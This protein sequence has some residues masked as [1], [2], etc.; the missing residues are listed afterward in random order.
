MQHLAFAAIRGRITSASRRTRAP[1]IF[2]YSQL[3]RGIPGGWIANCFHTVIRAPSCFNML[4]VF[5][6][7]SCNCRF[8]SSAEVDTDLSI[9]V[10]YTHH[11]RMETL[12]LWAHLTRS[13]APAPCLIASLSHHPVT[14]VS[15]LPVSQLARRLSHDPLLRCCCFW[16]FFSLPFWK[17]CGTAGMTRGPIGFPFL[18]VPVSAPSVRGRLRTPS[19][20]LPQSPVAKMWEFGVGLQEGQWCQRG[21]MASEH[22]EHIPEGRRGCDFSRLSQGLGYSVCLSVLT[23]LLSWCRRHPGRQRHTVGSVTMIHCHCPQACLFSSL[24][25]K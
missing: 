15:T 12:Y 13:T 8:L 18:S 20:P 2:G 16:G 25:K 11:C 10:H 24:I 17:Q 21:W 1:S 9:R 22:T 3:L 19:R 7:L 6:F 5:F 4:T 14:L 23:L